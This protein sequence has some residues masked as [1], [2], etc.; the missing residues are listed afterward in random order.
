MNRCKW[1]NLNNKIYQ[2]QDIDTSYLSK[3][4]NSIS[5]MFKNG[6]DVADFLDISVSSFSVTPTA[7]GALNNPAPRT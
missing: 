1:V 3:Y 6:S 2:E 5:G 4:V 7:N